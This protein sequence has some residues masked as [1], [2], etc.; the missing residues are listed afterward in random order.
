MDWRFVGFYNMLIL[1]LN[2]YLNIV[3]QEVLL[4][5]CFVV[6]LVMYAWFVL[7]ITTRSRTTSVFTLCISLPKRISACL[8]GNSVGLGAARPRREET[9]QVNDEGNDNGDEELL[10][11]RESIRIVMEETQG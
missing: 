4:V 1:T 9:V 10:V 8:L 6:L 5:V 3:N 2:S 7:T 11:E